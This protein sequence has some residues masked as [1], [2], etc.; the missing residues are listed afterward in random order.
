MSK[1]GIFIFCV[2]CICLRGNNAEAISIVDV[3]TYNLNEI[4]YD[5]RVRI[6]TNMN[7]FAFESTESVDRN[8]DTVVDF[9]EQDVFYAEGDSCSVYVGNAS[10]RYALNNVLMW[11]GFTGVFESVMI[12]DL[13]VSTSR[14][15]PSTQVGLR[16]LHDSLVPLID[17]VLLVDME[18]VVSTRTSTSDPVSSSQPLM[19]TLHNVISNDENL[20]IYIG[21]FGAIKSG[22]N[23][24]T[25]SNSDVLFVPTNNE[26]GEAAPESSSLPVPEPTTLALAGV[27]LVML[28]RKKLR[29]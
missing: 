16:W 5:N 28:L 15:I 13:S 12:D 17:S 27:G 18:S 4:T 20:R 14:A 11:V 7:D 1:T 2:L 26:E 3:T 8:G 21:A 29:G 10:S 25:P 9:L 22:F 24:Q 19:F 23:S 6:S